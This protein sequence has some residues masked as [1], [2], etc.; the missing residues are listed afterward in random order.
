MSCQALNAFAASSQESLTLQCVQ[1]DFRE[2]LKRAAK[3]FSSQQALADELGMSLSRLN[4]AL[5]KG[6][7][8]FNVLNCL[9]LASLSGESPSA[10]LRAGGKAEIADLIEKSYGAPDQTITAREREHLAQWRSIDDETRGAVNALVRKILS[11]ESTSST[12]NDSPIVKAARRVLPEKERIAIRLLT[13]YA[14]QPES[15]EPKALASKTRRS[16]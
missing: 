10:V 15:V 9:K 3:K 4:R 6:D 1:I 13:R 12:P 11:A 16:E 8:P 5:N 7:Y 2:L 14:R